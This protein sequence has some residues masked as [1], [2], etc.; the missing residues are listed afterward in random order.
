MRGRTLHSERGSI[1]GSG[2]RGSIIV[3]DRWAGKYFYYFGEFSG[4]GVPIWSIL[5]IMG[6][7]E[8]TNTRETKE[9]EMEL[10]KK[11]QQ[12]IA[13]NICKYDVVTN[14]TVDDVEIRIHGKSRQAVMSCAMYRT[15]DM[16]KVW[17]YTTDKIKANRESYSQLVDEH[18]NRYSF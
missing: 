2:H 12:W 11:E 9:S 3:L 6:V 4:L 8:E 1:R 16:H 5:T 15:T 13:D 10:T 7:Q 14:I 17:K 18:Y